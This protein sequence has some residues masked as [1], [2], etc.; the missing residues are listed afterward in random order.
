MKKLACALS[1]V[2]LW[3]LV[4]L[5]ATPGAF[6]RS[7][8]PAQTTFVRACAS[9]QVDYAS[10]MAILAVNSQFHPNSGGPAGYHP[11]D[12]QSAY[13]LPSASQGNGQTVAIVDAYDDPNAEADLGVY[14]STFG[15]PPCTTG[16]GCFKKVNQKGQQGNYPT[17]DHGWSAEISLDLDM[18]SAICPNCHILLVEANN[19]HF[20]NLGISVNT[21]VKLGANAVSNSY[22]GPEAKKEIRFQSNYYNHPGVAITASSGDSGYGSSAPAAF[23]TLTAVGGTHLTRGGGSRGWT[24]TAWSRAGS[25]CS[26]F[27]SKPSWQTDP[28]CSNRTI[29]DVSAVA[30]PATGVSVYDTYQAP[31]WQVYGGTSVSSPIVAS[32]YALA[33]NEGSINY[34]SYPYL[35]GNYKTNLYDVTSGSN[36]NCG[37]YICNAG[38]GYDG[39]TGLGTPN[40]TGAF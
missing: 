9:A 8:A 29:S 7:S 4:T 34:G 2:A 30:D 20:K 27:I 22:G 33:G 39:P 31:G 1:L 16:N 24:E 13:N 37:N 10:C 17:P 3:A 25:G 35:N 11:A 32:V 12:L 38:T 36:G 40:G 18:V 5:G 14:R 23:N 26:K 28:D 19:N 6:A 15:L 21:A